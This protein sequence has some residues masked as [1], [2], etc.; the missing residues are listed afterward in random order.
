MKLN[1]AFIFILYECVLSLVIGADNPRCDYSKRRTGPRLPWSELQERWT[2]VAFRKRFRM[3]K[4]SFNKLCSDINNAVG[5]G[6]FKSESHELARKKHRLDEAW[7][8]HGGIVSG[9]IKVA[10]YLR[11]L[12]GASYFDVSDIYGIHELSTYRIFYEVVGWVMKTYSFDYDVNDLGRL[13]SI[14][15]GFAQFS[16]HALEGCIGAIDGLAIRI[17][18]PSERDGVSDPGNYFCRKGFHALNVQAVVD[19]KKRFLFASPSHVGSA[20][21]ARAWAETGLSRKL[22]SMEEILIEHKLWLAGDSAYPLRSFMMTPYSK[23][24]ARYESAED[25]FNF[26]HSNSRIRVEC[27]F[28]EFIM[29]WGLFWKKLQLPLAKIGP[30]I[31][32]A[33]KVHNFLVDQREGGAERDDGEYWSEM[34][35]SFFE[36]ARSGLDPAVLE[37]GNKRDRPRT[38]TEYKDRR[39]RGVEMRDELRDKL[40]DRGM[41]RIVRTDIR[42]N[43]YGHVYT[44]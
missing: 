29:R 3:E 44:I 26:W 9:E 7:E 25:N 14:S 19:S 38:T 11:I 36:M 31:L 12:S 41:Q 33:M 15:N 2:D 42:R 1:K 8:V 18:C 16:G 22:D 5:A 13:Q 32:S 30:I 34:Y 24:E 39:K 35:P 37:T 23:K 4:H 21:D 27:A 40:A 6:V 10:V 17:R 43:E 28:G 20:N